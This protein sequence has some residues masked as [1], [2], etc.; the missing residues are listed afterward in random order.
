MEKEKDQA[1]HFG[2]APTQPTRVFFLPLFSFS[3]FSSRPSKPSPASP[4]SVLLRSQSPKGRSHSS[5][6]VTGSPS[7]LSS[8]SFLSRAA[9][10]R[11]ESGVVN[12]GDPLPS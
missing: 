9:R 1:S 12:P 5:A 3:P 6:P 10:A 11:H 7:F 2:P 4:R 8:S